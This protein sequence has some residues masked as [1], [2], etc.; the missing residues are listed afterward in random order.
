MQEWNSQVLP[1]R[2]DPADLDGDGE[3]D[4][5]DIAILEG[6]KEVD[7]SQYRNTGCCLAFMIIGATIVGAVVAVRQ[8]IA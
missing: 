7:R 3:F 6:D 1:L 4:A 2:R 5:I 8:I